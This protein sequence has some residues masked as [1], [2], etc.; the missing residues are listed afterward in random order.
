MHCGHLSIFDRSYSS[1]PRHICDN[2]TLSNNLMS[3]II[4]RSKK[5]MFCNFI[6]LD[7]LAI[8]YS[9]HICSVVSMAGK[10]EW[11]LQTT[12]KRNLEVLT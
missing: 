2:R 12:Q 9:L 11:S 6:H 10:F 7:R 4:P 3:T 8:G 5:Y 1:V